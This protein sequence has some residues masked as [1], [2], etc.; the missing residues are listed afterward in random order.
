MFYGSLGS[1][2]HVM[3]SCNKLC[4]C[5]ECAVSVTLSVR[6][7]ACASLKRRHSPTSVQ[8]SCSR[9]SRTVPLQPVQAGS[10]TQSLWNG[11][12]LAGRVSAG[13]RRGIRRTQPFG[14]IGRRMAQ[15]PFCRWKAGGFGGNPYAMHR[16]ER[17]FV[18]CAFMS[19]LHVVCS[20]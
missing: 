15:C 10:V 5:L 14:P 17:L 3:Q 20:T 18:L 4:F 19:G 9:G 16:E 13:T 6:V 8:V 2:I 11:E 7:A 12:R 1:Q